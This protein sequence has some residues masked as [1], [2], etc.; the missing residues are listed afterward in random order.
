MS[1]FHNPVGGNPDPKDPYEHY[2]TGSKTSRQEEK[3]EE[4]PDNHK[5]ERLTIGAYLLYI[6]HKILGFLLHF[7]KEKREAKER[8]ATAIFND[9]SAFKKE[10]NR[11]KSNDLSK[12]TNYLNQLCALWHNILEDSFIIKHKT[13][14]ASLFEELLRNV[15]S[16][17]EGEEFSLG[18]YLNEYAGQNWIPL[19][20]I[21][22]VQKL[23]AQH[24]KDPETSPLTV[25]TKQI[26]TILSCF[27][28]VI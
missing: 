19:P 27:D 14:A 9:L 3:Q 15:H 6:A 22:L 7:G 2:R 11:L 12:E 21:E 28:S 26:D 8:S 4:S 10:L 16:Y 20:Y 25:W 24:Q 13:S 17:P 1:P 23:F 18:Y 5:G